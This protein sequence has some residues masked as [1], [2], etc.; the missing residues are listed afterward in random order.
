[1]PLA[2]LLGQWPGL[3]GYRTC[4]ILQHIHFNRLKE[5]HPH[6]YKF[7]GQQFSI[8][9]ERGHE[10]LHR[11]LSELDGNSPI[12]G[13]FDQEEQRYL[14]T[15]EIN[16]LMDEFIAM[17]AAPENKRA[18]VQTASSRYDSTGVETFFSDVFEELSTGD[19]ITNRSSAKTNSGPAYR[20]AVG[21]PDLGMTVTNQTALSSSA[22][23]GLAMMV[24]VQAS[25]KAAEQKALTFDPAAKNGDSHLDLEPRDPEDT[26]IEAGVEGL[27]QAAELGG[28]NAGSGEP[29]EAGSG[30]LAEADSGGPAEAGNGE[31]AEAGNG[32][33]AEA[34]SG[35]PTEAGDAEHVEVQQVEEPQQQGRKKQKEYLVWKDYSQDKN[36]HTKA[37]DYGEQRVA[38]DL[39]RANDNRRRPT[40]EKVAS[41][42]GTQR[43]SG[44]IAFEELSKQME[45]GRPMGMRSRSKK[46]QGSPL[47]SR[48]EAPTPDHL[49]PVNYGGM[50]VDLSHATAFIEDTAMK[51]VADD[52]GSGSWMTN[53]SND[54]QSG[55]S[56]SGE[57][58]SD[59]DVNDRDDVEGD[60]HE[61]YYED[62]SGAI[63]VSDES[64]DD[65]DDG[66]LSAPTA[67]ITEKSTVAA[68][69]RVTGYIDSIN[70]SLEKDII[71]Q[72]EDLAISREFE[73]LAKW[74][75]VASSNCPTNTVASVRMLSGR[76]GIVLSGND[77]K[78]LVIPAESSDVQ[79]QWLNDNIIDAYAAAR[80]IVQDK[81]R[82]ANDTLLF[83]SSL[84]YG[85]ILKKSTGTMTQAAKNTRRVGLAP[86][87]EMVVMPVNLHGNHWVLACLDTVGRRSIILDPLGR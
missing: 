35:G 32:E 53:S 70:S 26:V 87:I 12:A 49:Q 75:R 43:Q 6:L 57:E 71:V 72:L 55:G 27:D 46:M 33:P 1:M 52:D 4:L 68:V 10:F 81:A 74:G 83:V 60:T 21:Y 2:W 58:S 30:A 82:Q 38:V 40:G 78:R 77:L 25:I 47:H 63:W 19:I 18:R 54:C 65:G 31:P 7:I 16:R 51:D 23:D 85:N 5:T 80:L 24:K 44:N 20:I 45:K 36:Y 59:S 86:A 28:A 14:F 62:A 69:N 76:G 64:G 61:G 42:E 39:S 11:V 41:G 9:S 67:R 3:T 22:D 79:D 34:D 66:K 48:E 56:E 50:R 73:E 13:D 17:R 37:R 29:A 84:I 8:F 15:Q